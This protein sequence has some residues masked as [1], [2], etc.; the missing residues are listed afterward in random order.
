MFG[1]QLYD[2]KVQI[3]DEV[4]NTVIKNA[5]YILKLSDGSTLE[6]ISD[7]NGLTETTLSSKQLKIDS[8]EII[9]DSEK[10]YG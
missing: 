9:P 6:G 2:L 8:I 7:E 5:K 1:N 3:F 4:K 10:E